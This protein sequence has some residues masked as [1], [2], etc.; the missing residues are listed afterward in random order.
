M[1]V[2]LPLIERKWSL[3]AILAVEGFLLCLFPPSLIFSN[4]I[5]TGGDTGP[6]FP[7]ALAVRDQL[8]SGGSPFTWVYGNYAGF[9]LFLNYFPLPF[10][11]AALISFILP[12][13]A[14]FK[15]TTLLAILPL[16]P[17]VYRCL[18]NLGYSSPIPALGGAFS[19]LF[20]MMSENSMWGGNI[21]STL[22][23]EFAYGIS[24]ALSIHLLGRL[25]AD[26]PRNG[27]PWSN[28][29]IEAAVALSNGYPLLQVGFGSTFFFW[30]RRLV[31]YT[32]GLHLAAFGMIAFWV[33]PLLWRIPWGTPFTH[34]WNISRWQEVLPPLLILPMGGIL[35]DWLVQ[36]ISR[37]T[38]RPRS[39][40]FQPC[41]AADP[42]APDSMLP[43][44]LEDP[45][46]GRN[47][48]Q[49]LWY[50]TGI[51][52]L[53]F[54]AA[55]TLG[56]VDI[57]FLPFTQI[58]LV[59][60]GAI[61]WGKLL[62]K[63]PHCN[64]L[65]GLAVL[66]V[67]ACAA[68]N[69]EPTSTWIR[70]NYSGF[71]N[72]PLWPAFHE[73]NLHLAGTMNDP[74]VFY[75]HAEQNN[76]AGSVRAFEMLPYFSGR[77][78]LEGL[79]MQSSISSPFVFYVQ[80]E[81]SH[82]PSCPFHSYYY[83]GFDPERASRHLRL[84]NVSQAIAVTD[85]TAAALDRSNDYSLD[86]QALPFR[87]Y[88]LK[89]ADPSYV[90]P[91]QYAPLRIP[92][93]NWRKMQSQWFRKSSLDV[94]LLV[95]PPY[96]DGGYW[97]GLD[98]WD[99]R[100]EAIPQKPLYDPSTGTIQASAILGDNTITVHTSKPMHPLW[101]KVSYHPDWRVSQGTCEVYLASPSFMILVPHSPTV[102]LTFDTRH[103]VYA[104]GTALTLMTLLLVFSFSFLNRRPKGF[105]LLRWA[106]GAGDSPNDAAAGR[107]II[108][109]W[110]WVLFSVVIIAALANRND[111]DPI[112]LYNEA[113]N[114]HERAL[115]IEKAASPDKPSQGSPAL[116][117]QQL[118]R[119]AERLFRRCLQKFPFS[120]VVDYCNHYLTILLQNDG[121]WKESQDLLLSFLADYP[122]TR[123]KAESLYHLG[124]CASHLSNEKGARDYF[125][126]V[127]V[128]YPQDPWA[129][130]AAFRLLEST[131]PQELLSEAKSYYE[132]DDFDRATPL[133]A[134]L[135]ERAPLPV[136]SESGLLYAFTFYDQSNWKEAVRIL[137]DWLSRYPNHSRASEAWLTL[138]KTQAYLQD[139]QAASASLEE[140]LKRDPSLARTQPSAAFIETIESLKDHAAEPLQPQP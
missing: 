15:L 129:G 140:A 46:I 48:E 37:R 97:R 138:S 91:L 19:L 25:Y 83:P 35:A 42:P 136:R 69:T 114:L 109:W 72:K 33:L 29:F 31:P 68:F 55:P 122:D 90:T 45:I 21:A 80:A 23:G 125:R 70:W 88:R 139:F 74:R 112:L 135:S 115:S 38:G 87:V 137:T 89:G 52:L 119:K 79:Y 5:I 57:R 95:T 63:L 75:E 49:Y 121:R 86:Y 44:P 27:R 43:D 106:S 96:P 12:M 82:G 61:G 62:R 2:F 20:L 100:A 8:L 17:I 110:V 22:A 71:E 58:F 24:F 111:R 108:R 10:F 28:A 6:H 94:P 101:L 107:P 130:H 102:V 50:Q 40:R 98:L 73:V 84:F 64:L 1:S 51:S 59:M 67:L 16:A 123:S 47:P 54:A 39:R 127:L 93:E 104:W 128:S 11:A 99:G 13:A 4:S 60:L 30:K 133:L 118:D 105:A 65:G 117:P 32:V 56:L 66:L 116:K 36:W 85:E 134:A 26:V 18:Q 76:G 92:Y 9:P 34:S 132:A 113:V 81:L 53:G 77:S 120:P 131:S 14:A 78:T 41:P 126:Q 7:T 124:L 3:L 103:G